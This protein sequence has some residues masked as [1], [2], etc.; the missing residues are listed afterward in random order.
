MA[1][2][3]G[4]V[5]GVLNTIRLFPQVVRSLKTKK[6]QDLSGYFVAILFLQSVFLIAYG[7]T[8]PDNIILYTNIAPLFCA[9]ILAKLKIKYS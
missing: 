8:K 9:V 4:I 1:E 3:F 5:G 6:T 2:F 7:F